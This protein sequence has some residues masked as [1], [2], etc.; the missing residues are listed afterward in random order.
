[1]IEVNPRNGRR[2]REREREREKE[3]NPL[4]PRMM[5]FKRVLLREGMVVASELC[6]RRK[7]ERK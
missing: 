6:D 5:T 4:S 3:T 1:M 2:E 7:K